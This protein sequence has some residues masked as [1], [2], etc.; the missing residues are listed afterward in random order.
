[1]SVAELLRFVKH[2]SGDMMEWALFAD[3]IVASIDI[4]GDGVVSR[5]VS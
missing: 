5:Y 3:D 4:N 1:M 2:S